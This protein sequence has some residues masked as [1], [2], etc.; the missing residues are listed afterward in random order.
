MIWLRLVGAFASGALLRLAFPVFD[1]TW[2]LWPA[3]VVLLVSV[4]GATP[5]QGALLGAAHS[6]VFYLWLLPWLG[7]IGTDAWILLSLVMVLWGAFLGALI[8]VAFSTRVWLFLV[9]TMYVAVEFMRSSWPLGGFSWGR[10]AFTSPTPVSS[11]AWLVGASGVT[12]INVAIAALI[13]I[14][15][16]AL[17]QRRFAR[18]GLIAGAVALVMVLPMLGVGLST[19]TYGSVTAA[20]VQGNVP[21]VGLDFNAQ[22]QAV[23]TNHVDTTRALAKDVR[24]GAVARPDFVIWPE[25]ASDIDPFTN[26]TA[27]AAIQ[28]AVNDIGVDV[29]VGAVLEK[30]D[31]ELTNTGIVW[32]PGRGATDRYSKLHLVPFGEYLPFRSVLAPLIGRFDRIRRDFVPGE[33]PGNLVIDGV[34]LGAVI[35]FEIAYDDSVRDVAGRSGVLVVQT[36]NATYGLTGQPQQQLAITQ[37]RA[38]EH[39]RAV[40]VAATSGISA[41]ITP[42]GRIAANQTLPEFTSG[43][44][45]SEIPVRPETAGRTPGARL[46]SLPEWLA[47]LLLIVMVAVKSRRIGPSDTTEAHA[48]EGQQ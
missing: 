44:V 26:P 21:R 12:F 3:L 24:A 15:G 23:L 22:R 48:Q 17:W 30:S 14:A 29:L 46:G 7:V 43:Y 41:I 34:R 32:T 13:L 39:G 38:I 36:N 4:R 28:S 6:L 27:G 45:V 5:R 9:P 31:T 18:T 10:V 42:D 47:V 2:L 1:L 33:R 11:W 35:C 25:N 16:K 8:A 19:S 20:V 40:L 37:L